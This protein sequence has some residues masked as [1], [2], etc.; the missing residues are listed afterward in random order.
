MSSSIKINKKVISKSNYPFIIAEMSGNHKK[1]LKRAL[2][3]V[4]IAADSGANAI[5]L[6]TFK[7]EKVTLNLKSQDFIINDKTSPWYKKKIF[8]LF[9]EA[10]TPWEWH[11][12][13]FQKAKSRG[14]E[15]LSTPFHEEAVDFFAVLLLESLHLLPFFDHH[16]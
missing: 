1:S 13:I 3:I 8:K 15:F 6:Q 11:K 2:K 12:E 4:D 16:P 9:Q 5:K 14:L 7:P 10:Y